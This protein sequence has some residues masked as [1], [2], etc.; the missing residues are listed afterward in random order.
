MGKTHGDGAATV[1]QKKTAE[2]GK[3]DGKCRKGQP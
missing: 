2:D 1:C 3:S